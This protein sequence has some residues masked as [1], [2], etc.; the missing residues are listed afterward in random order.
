MSGQLTLVNSGDTPLTDWSYTFR[1]T[2]K[3]VQVWSSSYDVVDLGDGTYEVTVRPP[4]W[5][6]SIPAGDSLSL[7]FNAVS[8]DL[9]TS[10]PLTDEMFFADASVDVSVPETEPDTSPDSQP[11][12]DSAHELE[13]ESE[14]APE[15]LQEVEAPTSDAPARVFKVDVYSG[16][17]S[18]FRPGIDRLD[19]GG[20]SVH[21]LILGK[22]EEG[23]V[24]FLSPWN[25]T[26]KMTLVGVTYDQL[27]L[28]DYGVVGNEHLRQDL[29]GVVSWELGIGQKDPNTTYIRSHEYGK[30]ETITDFDPTTD[31]ISFLYYG[32]RERLSVTQDGA[33][34]VISTE[35][36]GQTFI[37]QNTNLADIP[38]ASLEFHF[39][40]IVEDNL[41]IPFGRSVDSLTLKDRTSLLTPAAP[42]GELTDGFQT[43]SGDA[44]VNEQPPH[45]SH[46]MGDDGSMDMDPEMEM[47][48]E[49][50]MDSGMDMPS[51]S[52][53]LS[54]EPLVETEPSAS[55]LVVSATITGG[56]SGTF[57]GNVTVTNTTGASVG[58]D[59]TVSFVSDAPL[60][61]VSNF[62]F[63]NT[64]RDDG[65]Y[66]V[67]LSPK[68][69]SAPLAAGSAQSS[70][71]QGSGDFVDPNQVFDLGF[72]SAEV[73]QQQAE[74]ETDPSVMEQQ[75]EAP[76]QPD[77]SDG[78]EPFD[79]DT[80][81]IEG[82]TP[83][84]DTPVTESGTVI[85]DYERPNGTTDKRVVTYF[86]E[87]GIYS[88]DVNL[89]DVD[90]QS[91]T[92][93][94][95]S[96]FDVRADGSITLFD[97]FAALQKRFPEAD[98]V[99]RTF[100]SSEYAA[101]AP[102]LLDIYE[103]SGRYTTSQ[104]GDAITVTSVPVGWNGV[105]TNDAGNFEQL[106][107]FKE[108]N[109]EVNLGFALGGWT[110]SDEFSTAYATQEGRDKFVSETVR[111][112][113]T[114][115]FFTVVDFDWEYP[116]GGGKAG[117]A[118]SASDG[119][120]FELVLRDLRTALDDL[121]ARTG[122][123]FEVSVATAGGQEKLANLNLQGIDPYVDFYNVMTYDFHGGW[124]N[125]TGHQAAMTGDANNYDVTGAVDVFENAGIELSKVV[126]GAPAYTRAWG[127]V[128]DGGTFG[129]QQ[130]GSGPDSTGSFEAGIYDYKDVLNDVITGTRNLYWDDDNKAAFLYDGDEW[131]SMETTATIAGKAAY[132]EEKGLGGMMFWAL[133]NDTEGEASLVEAADDLLRKGASYAEVIE[134]APEFDAIIGGN[135]DF[136]LTDFTGL[137]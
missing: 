88:R 89:S 112:F 136:S 77:S 3:D 110:L 30:V 70:Y 62:E 1:T 105:G 85:I 124:E 116:G 35:P 134:R 6:A 120:N 55:G 129:Y 78:V 4:E 18:D 82:A 76:Q 122:R 53:P 83:T 137:V 37:F 106:R 79:G 86:E 119:A 10:G 15:S 131:S 94:N 101:M 68:S 29:G 12:P 22:T 114:Y 127:N 60:K 69:W 36:T 111:I 81:A 45:D 42:D 7:S 118:V 48:G 121:S 44:A 109:P 103:N 5:G 66:V 49:M 46:S 40:Q 63:T 123:D 117:N 102:E 13:P 24:T 32:T 87:W 51:D 25:D 38:G 56:W 8:V 50:G 132:V 16:E 100:S 65:R 113:E 47:D 97:E 72:T 135:G 99:S 59:W 27:A 107:R 71:Y 130:P 34:L 17:V 14:P 58:T 74:L 95:Y 125:V 61:T 67:T 64:L 9:P 23:Y 28:D 73:P 128:A 93:M 31:K 11:E 96:F 41:E 80:T 52:E 108:L 91:M 104:N 115:D 39:D 92:H 2:Q 20:Q 90:G 33:D 26:Q 43:Q 54:P 98:Q 75:P 133:S 57:A 126:M 84:E 19:F 21:N